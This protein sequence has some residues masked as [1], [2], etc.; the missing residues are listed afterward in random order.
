MTEADLDMIAAHLLLESLALNNCDR[1]GGRYCCAYHQ[2]FED[3][4]G[5]MIERLTHE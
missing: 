5:M 3:G 4:M 1:R 2:G